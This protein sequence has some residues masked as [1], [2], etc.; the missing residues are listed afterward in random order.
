MA[1]NAKLKKDGLGPVSRAVLPHFRVHNLMED[2]V[3]TQL[4]C[5]REGSQ[6]SHKCLT[7][8]SQMS[9]RCRTD[10][11]SHRYRTDVMSHRCRTDVSQISHRCEVSQMMPTALSSVP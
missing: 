4:P 3:L 1:V 8:V 2:E 9:H 6:M 11:M 7:D 5:G 10:V